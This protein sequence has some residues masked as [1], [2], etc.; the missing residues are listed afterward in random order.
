MGSG[1][2]CNWLV[3]AFYSAPIE[4]ESGNLEWQRTPS[5]G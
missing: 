3:E 2:R 1:S 5:L 4:S